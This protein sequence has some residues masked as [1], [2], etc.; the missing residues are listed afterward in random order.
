MPRAGA[1]SRLRLACCTSKH[2]RCA[3]PHTLG[4]NRCQQHNSASLR[5]ADIACWSWQSD[6]FCKLCA[7]CRTPPYSC[8]GSALA[9]EQQE[10]LLNKKSRTSHAVQ[11]HVHCNHHTGH[12]RPAEAGPEHRV[13]QL[14]CGISICQDPAILISKL[15]C[16]CDRK[17]LFSKARLQAVHS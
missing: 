4:T 1:D 10:A 2:D 3:C 14:A 15:C 9:R 12:V 16:T 13:L 6:L 7:A 8:H 5:A 17:A 11:S